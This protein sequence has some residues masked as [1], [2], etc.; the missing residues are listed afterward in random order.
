[1]RCTGSVALESGLPD[2]SSKYADE[3]SAAHS[4]ASMA[5]VE[6][7]DAAAYHGRIITVEGRAGAVG[8]DF[9][10]DA[11]MVEEVQKY[12]DKIH[13][14]ANGQTLLVEQRL[15]FSEY[16]GV[17]DQF[18]TSDAVI[19]TSDEIQ[20]HDLKYGRGVRV[21]AEE[22]EQLMLYALGALAT[23][24]F[25]GEFKR[26]R[27]AIHQP[28]LDHLSEWDCSIEDLLAFATK[29]AAAA[30]IAMSLLQPQNLGFAIPSSHFNPGDKQCRWCKA[31]S[32]CPALTGEVSRIVY[33]SP[34]VLGNKHETAK[35]QGV[36]Q[37]VSLLG[38]YMDRLELVEEWCK[39]IRARVYTELSSGAEVPGWKMVTGKKGNRAWCDKLAAETHM[40]G[41]RLKHEEMFEYSLISPTQAEKKLAKEYPRAWPK[42]AALIMQADGRPTMVPATDLRQPLTAQSILDDFSDLTT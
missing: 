25:I 5:L 8:T 16:V 4:L 18:G 24:G 31:K 9:T 41:M 33:G 7:K 35:P 15:E 1:M 32:S 2:T 36:P 21:D 17:A 20:V 29:A 34:D 22:N 10:V 38:T 42:L 23:F 6:E 3:G 19:L 27:M 26:V 12:L 11:E 37:S 14:F 28:R 40:K 13:E 39:A 30:A